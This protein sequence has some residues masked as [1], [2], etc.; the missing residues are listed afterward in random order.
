MLKLLEITLRRIPREHRKAFFT[1]SHRIFSEHIL[2][3]LDRFKFEKTLDVLQIVQRRVL[4]CV[5]ARPAL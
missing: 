5:C 4:V 1:H 3:R 2:S